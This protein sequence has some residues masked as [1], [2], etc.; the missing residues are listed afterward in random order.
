MARLTKRLAVIALT[1]CCVGC[2]NQPAASTA[3]V[4]V[5]KPKEQAPT[6]T[7]RE[8]EANQARPQMTFQI[9]DP[10]DRGNAVRVQVD[11]DRMRAYDLSPDLILESIKPSR[12]VDPTEPSPPPGVVFA[13]RV[14]STDQYEDIIVK[15][16]AEGE[17]VRLKDIATVEAEPCGK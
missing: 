2:G 14:A 9:R 3:E 11:I 17:I 12:I 8:S 7:R 5:S 1:V 15:A 4:P 16:T 10:W 6:P 13:N